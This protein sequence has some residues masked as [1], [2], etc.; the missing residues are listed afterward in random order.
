MEE[1]GPR[2]PAGRALPADVGG[3]ELEQEWQDAVSGVLYGELP[4]Y[5][6]QNPERFRF[7]DG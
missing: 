4:R 5:L 1:D 6:T 3:T 2:L 7:A